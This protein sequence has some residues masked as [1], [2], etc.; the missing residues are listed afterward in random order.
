MFMRAQ[1]DF[2]EMEEGGLGSSPRRFFVKKEWSVFTCAQGTSFSERIVGEIF[3]RFSLAQLSGFKNS[4]HRQ[5]GL[6]V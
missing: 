4:Y 3:L 1:G 5:V 6:S 2:I